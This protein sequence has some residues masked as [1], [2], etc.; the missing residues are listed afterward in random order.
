MSVAAMM[1]K[2]LNRERRRGRS[3]IVAALWLPELSKE[4]SNR[5]D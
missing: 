2:P 3:E 4:R 1:G 5:R